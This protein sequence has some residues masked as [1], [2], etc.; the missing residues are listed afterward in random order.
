MTRL[1]VPVPDSN[2]TFAGLDRCHDLDSLDADIAILG[3]P[4]GV[5]YPSYTDRPAYSQGAAAIRQQSQKFGK[6]MDHYDVDFGGPLLNGKNIRM[7]DC[8]D[9]VGEETSGETNHA[10]IVE[11]VRK[12]RSKGAVAITIGGNDS[13]ST[14]VMQGLDADGEVSVVHFDAHLDFRDEVEGLTNGWSSSIRRAS[15]MEHI[16]SI[17]QLGL[18]GLGSARAGDYDDARANGNKLITAREIHDR[19]SR[20]IASE[21]PQM[22]NIYIP[23]DADVLDPSV[24]PA[25]GAAAPGGLHYWQANDLLLAAAARGNVVA[26]NFSSHIPE[27]ENRGL[28]S[29]VLATLI[30]NLIG[31]MARSEQFG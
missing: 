8:G 27:L 22:G 12:I 21:L 10:R 3:V 5:I 1:T 24:A 18:R 14:P 30:M 16:G 26:A 6:F 23:F 2:L 9:V 20:E 13:N 15:E 28:T 29:L 19:G 7:V 31:A 11:A 17:T 25:A 4:H